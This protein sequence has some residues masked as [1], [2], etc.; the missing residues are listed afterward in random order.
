MELTGCDLSDSDPLLSKHHRYL[1]GPARTEGA[2]PRG[3]YPR[4]P[5]AW[6]HNKLSSAQYEGEAALHGSHGPLNG[7]VHDHT[8]PKHFLNLTRPAAGAHYREYKYQCSCCV[9]WDRLR[10]RRAAQSRYAGAVDEGRALARSSLV[11]PGN[12]RPQSP[13]PSLGRQDAFCDARTA[14]K[15]SFMSMSFTS[16]Y[17]G[18]VLEEKEE[19][20]DA[21]VEELY[22]LGLLYDDEHERGSGF[23][24]DVL[25]PRNNEPQYRVTVRPAK[26]GRR[27][28]HVTTTREQEEEMDLQ[29]ALNLSMSVFGDDEALAAFLISPDDDERGA[30]EDDNT[31][32]GRRKEA[33]VEVSR[34]PL[35]VIYE[36]EGDDDDDYSQEEPLPAMAEADGGDTWAFLNKMNEFIDDIYDDDSNFDH[37]TVSIHSDDWGNADGGEG[38]A[39]K[40]ATT[41]STTR[42][43][44]DFGT[45]KEDE[46][47]AWV[48]LSSDH[49]DHEDGVKG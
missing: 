31:D 16:G 37:N 17:G 38:G 11:L 12:S 15:R 8:V 2:N 6:R 27:N 23:T 46:D 34:L 33:E 24:F 26:R 32:E 7:A 40:V 28:H 41:I 5:L 47:D 25:A 20:A 21:D 48:V 1:P 49:S 10:S 19:A 9:A 22:R 30:I 35:K 14:K 45:D 3:K 39:A 13:P 36:V 4:R 29:L 18:D 42:S 44:S 43:M